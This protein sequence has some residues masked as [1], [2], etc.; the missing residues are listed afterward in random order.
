MKKRKLL[1][2]RALSTLE[3]KVMSGIPLA[4]A[5]R[6]LEIDMS[7]P[8]V[9]KLLK[10]LTQADDPHLNEEC[11][12]VISLSLFPEWI[13]TDSLLPQEQPE[14]YKYIGHFPTKGE[15]VKCKQ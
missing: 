4:V 11:K 7:R 15:W 8:A 6:Q 14:D 12:L 13:D 2:S 3:A 5:M 10:Y 9:A 1:S